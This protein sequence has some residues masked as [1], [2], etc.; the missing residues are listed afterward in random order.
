MSAMRIP[1]FFIAGAPKCGT[2]ALYSYL[3]DH[4]GIFMPSQKEINYFSE[5]LAGFRFRPNTLESY[6]KLFASAPENALC[7]DASS[8]HLYSKVTIPRIMVANPNAKIVVMLRNPS[9]AVRSLHAQQLYTLQEDVTD[10]KMAWALQPH[11]RFGE[12]LPDRC[13]EPKMLFYK[14]IFSYPE[15]I[16]RLLDYVPQESRLVLIF[17]EFVRDVPHFYNLVLRLLGLPEGD[18]SCFQSINERKRHRVAALYELFRYPP[19]PLNHMREPVKRLVNALGWKPLQLLEAVNSK[20]IGEPALDPEFEQE[21]DRA[22]AAEIKQ[23][24]RLLGRNLDIW[25]ERV[26]A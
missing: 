11:R 13:H 22:F 15:Q 9:R 20:R 1:D 16:A 12:N 3:N 5:D 7:G 25:R 19:F 26:T 14:D 21:L 4:H 8:T 17:E 6:L 10:L 24:E 2:T 23:L 18:R